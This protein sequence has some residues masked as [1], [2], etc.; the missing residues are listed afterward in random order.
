MRKLISLSVVMLLFPLLVFSQGYT[1]TL[2]EHATDIIEGQTTYRMYVD[3]VNGNDFLTSV[4]GGP[5]YP[6]SIS[7]STGSFYNDP[8]GS[9]KAD[10]INPA[11]FA[12]FPTLVGDSWITIGIESQ[13]I[14]DEV[15]IG[16]VE[17]PDQPFV[18]CFASG[19]AID[20]EDV[21]IDSP[22]GGAWYVLN[23]T[24]NG[25]PDENM[26]VLVMQMTTDGE[27]CG[28]MKFQI[29]ENGNG[30]EG[31]LR[32]SYAFCGIGTY[33]PVV[34]GC[35]DLLACNYD[36]SATGEDGSCVYD[37]CYG[38]TDSEACNYDETATLSDESCDYSCIGCMDAWANNYD[39]DATVEHSGSCVYCSPGTFIL[40]IEMA[41]SGGDGWNGS[42]YSIDS[43]NETV[44]ISGNYDDAATY[45]G[46][47]GID[48]QCL[49]PGCYSF[50]HGGGSADGENSVAIT[51][52]FGTTY[53]DGLN[54]GVNWN[55]DF[56]QTGVCG[57]EGCTN[58]FALNYNISATTDD[59][60]C[61]LPPSNNSIFSAAPIT[62]EQALSGSLLNATDEEG[63]VS[64]L[65]DNPIEVGGVW[66]VFN[67]DANYQVMMNTCNTYTSFLDDPVLNT[68]LHVFIENSDGE[69][70]Q[71]VNNDDNCGLMS[72]LSFQASVGEDYFVHVS[73]SSIDVAGSEFTLYVSCLDCSDGTDGC[74][75]I[76]DDEGNCLNDFD[77]D[78]VCNEFEFFG[79]TFEV[80]CNFNPTATEDDGSCYFYC[81]GC[82]DEAACNYD[83]GAIQEDGSCEYPVDWYGVDYVDCDNVCLNDN[84]GD[85]VCDEDEI[86]GC[87]DAVACNF[88]AEATD[89]LIPCEYPNEGYDCDGS[90]LNDTDGDGVCDLFDA[91]PLDAENDADGD[92]VCGNDEVEGCT[93]E[94]A[95]NFNPA[96]TDDDGTCETIQ[97]L[98]GAMYFNCDCTC[99]LDADGDGICDEEEVPG[100]QE[101]SACNFNQE[102][103]DSDGSCEWNSCAGC[104]YAFACNFDSDAVYSDGSCEFGTCPGCTDPTACNFNPTVSEDDGS[105]TVN[106]E[107]G[108]CGGSGPE[109]GYSCDGNCLD[110]DQ[111]GVCDFD[112]AGCTDANA[113][114]FAPLAQEDDGSC[115]YPETCFD[116]TGACL[117]ENANGIC[118][119]EEVYG[120]T[121]SEA[122]NFQPAA[123]VDDGSC[124]P[125]VYVTGGCYS[126]CPTCL[127]V[128]L[129]DADGDGVCDSAEIGSCTDAEA[130]N[131]DACA[132][133]DDGSCFYPEWGYDCEGNCTVDSDGDGVCDPE[134]IPGCTYS[135]AC[136]FV[137]EATEEDGSCTI[138]LTGYDC[139]GQCLADD[140]G[141][142]ICNE[143]EVPGCTDSTACN[144]CPA[145]TEDDGSCLY[146]PNANY[147]CN[148][149]CVSDTD[150]DG[151]CDGLEV[152]GCTDYTACNFNPSA[153][154]EDGSCTW[155]EQGLDCDGACLLDMDGNGVC[156]DDELT[157]LLLFFN[158]GGLCG[159][160]TYWNESS[161]QCLGADDCPMDFDGNGDIGSGDLL[162]FL[163]QYGSLCL[164]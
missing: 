112:E 103:T 92:G 135:G 108:Q 3:M 9:S 55:I 152:P 133:D 113:C 141:D 107:C 93:N 82:T 155:P 102:A 72:N 32:F 148:L 110:E 163:A 146:P 29:F 76:Y 5:A 1:L 131:Y 80:A 27:I 140:D 134:E 111:D 26:R 45:I 10:G 97:L 36:V 109:V 25:L 68:N 100:C 126:E 160:G 151:V 67:A 158:S 59:G 58:S 38:C 162:L 98:C 129:N 142:G 149:E 43:S 57:F 145:A 24:P 122:C 23:G 85:G 12:F 66:Y 16:V 119:C 127:G 47:V 37:G 70:I 89:Q 91:C 8:F 14:G 7:T 136:N 138:A 137:P 28:T 35:T 161:G 99:Q 83:A 121:D 153:T 94:A 61:L 154:E 114:N 65:G 124:A 144:F 96:A 104:I 33:D 157:L 48:F 19:S 132:T 69:L 53:V 39:P 71:V 125:W 51:D 130:C 90:C 20:G 13:P 84:D 77:G 49:S 159:P 123:N 150:G 46:G 34:F 139:D 30:Q 79:C 74:G 105:C 101:P 21:L 15:A 95:C 22:T 4:Y 118:D 81:P 106:D 42:V 50:V 147:N 17:D 75:D 88:F 62:C 120:C 73:R 6:L 56:A 87:T 40:Q 115:T 116:C 60:S 117:D 31:D 143:F 156:D 78:G 11:F 64:G 86:P 44:F 41:D 54:S 63:L 2:E 18:D 164:E 52:Q 128:L